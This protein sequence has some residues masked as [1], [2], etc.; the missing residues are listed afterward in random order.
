MIDKLVNDYEQEF[1]PE[2]EQESI[3]VDDL[4]QMGIKKD[5][6]A[7][8]VFLKESYGD[9]IF[10]HE[11]IENGDGATKS[12]QKLSGGELIRNEELKMVLAEL[13]K[14]V[15]DDQVNKILAK[16]KYKFHQ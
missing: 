4:L 12:V 2:I 9:A 6:M 16:Q 7:L 15:F 13:D 3:G 14:S 1:Q 10:K 11:E 8:E 5:T